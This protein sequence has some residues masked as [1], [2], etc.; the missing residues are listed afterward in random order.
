VRKWFFKLSTVLSDA[1]I[2]VSPTD[3]ENIQRTNIKYSNITLIPHVINFERYQYDVSK[4]QKENI[5][6]TIVWMETKENVIRKGVDK[7]LYSYKEL[8]K[9][10]DT[11]KLIIIGSEGVGTEYLKNLAKEID[12]FDKVI[13]TGR[14]EESEKIDYL[15]RSKFYFQLSMYEGFGIAAIEALAAGNLVVH[16]GKGGLGYTIGSK[17]IQVED[18]SDYKSIGLLLTEINKNYSN[19]SDFIQEGISHIQ[20]NFSYDSRKKNIRN[21][22]ERIQRN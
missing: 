8:L 18:T 2:I 22:L 13:F 7:L 21:V 17:G 3:L 20:Y 16:S 12:V 15:K 14:I 9:Y 11:F 5:I 1:N 19:Y 4:V 10:D 6:T